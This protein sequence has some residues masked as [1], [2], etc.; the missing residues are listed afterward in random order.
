MVAPEPVLMLDDARRIVAERGFTPATPA[1]SPARLG[2]EIE[3]HTVRIGTPDQPV[4]FD[5]LES[6]AR[7]I[8]L[9]GQ[10]RLTFEPGGQVELSSRPL[11]GFDAC[12]A[13]LE[14]ARALT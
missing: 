12:T 13:I 1:T 14:D 2:I 8:H 5:L 4:P 7:A 11:P 3:W 10:S 6:A 9:P